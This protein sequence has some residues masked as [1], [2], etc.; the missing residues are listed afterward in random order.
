MAALPTARRDL[1]PIG[2]IAAVLA[3]MIVVRLLFLGQPAGRDEAG[4]LIVGAS[5]D[6][7]PWLYGQFWVDRPP[8]LIWLM[9]LA[10]DLTGLRLMGL[11]A[12]VL[13]VLG[14]ARAAHVVRGPRAA[15]WAAAAAA[16]FST[17]HW[18]GVPRTNGEMLAAPFVAWGIALTAQALLRP[19]P[20]S[21]LFALMAGVLAAGAALIKQTVVDGLVFAAVL[22]ALVASQTPHR[23]RDV[24]KVVAAG[25]GGLLIGIGLALLAAAARGTTPDELFEALV[26]FRVDAGE[27]IRASASDA[28]TERLWVLVGTWAVSGLAL[29]AAL[30]VWHTARTR[31]PVLLAIL[32]VITFVSA[33]A[34]LG[35]SYWAHY[36]LQLV[37]ASALAAGLLADHV[38]PPWR[39]VA[40]GLVVAATAANL[41]FT[42]VSPPADGDEAQVVGRWLKQSGE[43]DDTAVVAYGQPNVL[44]NAEMSSPYPYLW[45]LPVRTLD[46][47]LSTL[48]ATL[49]SDERPTWFV[50]WSGIDSWGIRDPGSV[51][52]LLDR[53]YRQ[54][55]TI[56]DR[57]IWLDRTTTRTLAAPKDC[58]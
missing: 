2:F 31:E 38:R 13:M 43:P 5:W 32:A 21:W 34:L 57:T 50:D 16:L 18:F 46:P 48:S 56:C 14:V 47:D 51:D 33:T 54:V 20:R 4:F 17:A 58:P 27:V 49:E 36:L 42:T 10:R 7:G 15:V 55:A 6:D 25:A 39:T 11:L 40:A 30:T 45:S 23:R 24:V 3:A 19:G 29:I 8:L 35:G 52:E 1:R 9:E 44:G 26:T 12:S 41:L 37:P 22:A 28:T 53:H